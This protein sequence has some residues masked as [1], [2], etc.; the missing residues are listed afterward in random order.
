MDVV[1]SVTLDREQ[2]AE[3][4]RMTMPECDVLLF[5]DGDWMAYGD[6]YDLAEKPCGCLFSYGSVEGVYPFGLCIWKLP[7][8][9]GKESTDAEVCITALARHLSVHLNCDAVC[10]G[11]AYGDGSHPYF[12]L[13]WRSGEAWLADD[14]GADPYD[15]TGESVRPI[16][17]LTQPLPWLAQNGEILLR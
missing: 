12:S 1:L 14:S 8:R 16:C 4:F 5:A 10:D 17:R 15:G 9:T 3:M 13:L 2:L 6:L 7:G 11:T